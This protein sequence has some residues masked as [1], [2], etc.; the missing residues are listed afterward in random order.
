MRVQVLAKMPGYRV[1]QTVQLLSMQSPAVPLMLV[2]DLI[3]TEK[4]VPWIHVDWRT[5]RTHE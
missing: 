1:L 5:Q 3:N 2:V 4:G